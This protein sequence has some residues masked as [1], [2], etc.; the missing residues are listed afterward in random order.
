MKIPIQL[1]Y[2]FF[3]EQVTIKKKVDDMHIGEVMDMYKS[4]MVPLFGEYA[5]EKSIISLAKRIELRKKPSFYRKIMDWFIYDEKYGP[6][7]PRN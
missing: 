5:Y 3:D 7:K 4:L 1:S 6:K 2:K